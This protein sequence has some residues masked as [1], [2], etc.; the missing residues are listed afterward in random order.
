MPEAAAPNRASG[1]KNMVDKE[2]CRDSYGPDD[3]TPLQKNTGKKQ[4]Y[5]FLSF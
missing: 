1:W 4:V 5:F 3:D 2:F